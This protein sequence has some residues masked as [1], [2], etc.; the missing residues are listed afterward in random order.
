M[1]GST[2]ITEGR[3]EQKNLREELKTT[4]SELTY[5]K[6]SEMGASMTENAAKALNQ[7][8][9]NIFVG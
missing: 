5:A 3:D 4:L 9:L 8:P 2:L 7:V 6:L 1:N